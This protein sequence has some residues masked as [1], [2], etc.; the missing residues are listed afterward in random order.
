VLREPDRSRASLPPRRPVHGPGSVRLAALVAPVVVAALGACTPQ[1]ARVADVAAG[2]PAIFPEHYLH[3]IA[4]LGY[5]GARRAFQV[6]EG[7]QIW[8]GDVALGWR[9]IEPAGDTMTTPVYYER[10]AVPVAHWTMRDG[11]NEVAFEAAAAPVDALGDTSLMLAVRMIAT[12]RAAGR[13]RFAMEAAV[14]NTATGPHVLPWD[15]LDGAARRLAADRGL[16]RIGSRVA[17]SLP[18]P[19]RAD[20]AGTRVATTLAAELA[21]GESHTWEFWMPVFPSAVAASRLAAAG[22]HAGIVA[23]T[24]RHW[25]EW[26]ARASRLDTPDDTLDTAWRAALVT[27]IQCQERDSGRFVPMGNPLQYRDVWI[28]D[29]ARVVRALAVA[30]L[31]DM[32]REDARSLARFQFP[33]G[34]LVSQRGQLDGTGQ[35]LWAFDQATALPPS[36]EAARDF[37]PFARGAVSWIVRTRQTT[38]QLKLA[39]GGLM[40]FADPRDNE[41]VRAE[42]VGN[43]AWTLAGLR[44]ARTLALRAGD[45]QLAGRAGTEHDAYLADFRVALARTNSA[46]VPPSWRGPGRDWGNLSACYPTGVIAADDPRLA[47][48]DARKSTERARTGLITSGHADSLHTYLGADLAQWALLAGR[49][50]EARR[51]L[52][53]ILGHSSSTL[54]Q[55][56]IFHRD[57]GFGINMPPHGTAAATLVD[58]VRNMI[59]CDV[60]DTLEL[61]LGGDAAWWAGT[62]LARAPTRF[63][64]I[65]VSLGRDAAGTWTARYGAVRVPVR[66]RVPDGFRVAEIVTPGAHAAGRYIDGDGA[67]GEIAFRLAPEGAR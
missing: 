32:A 25:R 36:P 20:A 16:V 31:S 37:V 57:G 58:L 10:D 54:G 34:A 64:V 41:L 21:Q 60:R 18:A 13:G 59:V 33:T 6:G 7:S 28:R 42:L 14:S 35:A 67:R 46:D 52:R 62:R 17:A 2:E 26:L 49:P 44:S 48:L 19:A 66:V 40:P 1:R 45:V 15:A 61:A 50:E 56:E 30:G 8:N 5:P 47:R 55:A 12:R 9:W 22:A 38:R 11:A 39:W 24:R 29:G 27:L 65:D 23:E 63:G 51:W 3:S 53:G 4:A 43:D